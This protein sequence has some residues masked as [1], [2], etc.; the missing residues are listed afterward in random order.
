MIPPDD[1]SFVK[2]RSFE[3]V[4]AWFRNETGITA[5]GHDVANLPDGGKVIRFRNA[6]GRKPF[7]ATNASGGIRIAAGFI[8]WAGRTLYFPEAVY[9]GGKPGGVFIRVNVKFSATANAPGDPWDIVLDESDQYKPTLVWRSAVD[10][11]NPGATGIGEHARIYDDDPASN[12]DIRT[13]GGTIYL[14]IATQ[15]GSKIVQDFSTAIDLY[16]LSNGTMRMLE[17]P[18]N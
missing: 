1:R 4:L 2:L 5:P 7:T 18:G 16:V 15:Y 3:K 11:I 8:A 13:E 9:S 6:S 10:W 17:R 14:P 12:E